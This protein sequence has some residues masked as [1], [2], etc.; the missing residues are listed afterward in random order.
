MRSEYTGSDRA[1]GC[2]ENLEGLFDVLDAHRRDYDAVA[3]SSVITMPFHFH[4]DYFGSE[5]GDDKPV[6]R[7]GIDADPRNF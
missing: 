2:V 4:G 1:A 3:L 7:C 5:G 6:G